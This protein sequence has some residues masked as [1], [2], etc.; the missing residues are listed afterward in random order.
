MAAGRGDEVGLIYPYYYS[1]L[2]YDGMKKMGRDDIVTLARCAYLGAQKFGTLVWSG[3][4]PSP[5]E[6]LAAQ[7]KSGL[8]MAMCG[9][10]WWTTDIGGFYGG[11]INSDY[12]RELIVRWFQYGVFCPVKRLHGSREGHDRTRD[13]IEP[14]GGENELWSFGDAVFG[15]LKDLVELREKLRP[16][17][18]KHMEIVAKTGAPLMRPMFFDYPDD[19]ECY[20]TGE[21]YMFGDDILFAPIVNQGQTKKEVYLPAGD[22]I[23]T[24]DKQ[25]FEGGRKYTVKAAIDEIIVFV[26]KGA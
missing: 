13:I 6:S 3:D 11:D 14:T 21:Q 26:K 20:K 23:F 5:F 12:F 7:V 10:P 4:I 18:E 1:K 24:R 15:I 16:Y 25:T 8:N 19:E 2:A 9:I 17:I 22:W